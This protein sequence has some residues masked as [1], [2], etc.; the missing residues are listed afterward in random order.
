MFTTHPGDPRQYGFF[1]ALFF[2]AR[3]KP[4]GA[5]DLGVGLENA[6]PLIVAFALLSLFA[7]AVMLA[8]ARLSGSARR[9]SWRRRV[10]ETGETLRIEDLTLRLV[11]GRFVRSGRWFL[12]AIAGLAVSCLLLAVTAGSGFVDLA[13]FFTGSVACWEASPFTKRP[14]PMGCD[15][16]QACEEWAVVFAVSDSRWLLKGSCGGGR[17]PWWL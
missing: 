16:H 7:F 8:L 2:E 6:V 3:E 11:V 17:S 14:M 10:S 5:L 15:G 12:A 1:G 4:T 13:V 9:S